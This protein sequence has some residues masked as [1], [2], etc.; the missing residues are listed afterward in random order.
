MSQQRWAIFLSGKGS[1]AQAAL[2]CCS[3]VDIRLVVSSREDAFGLV[4]ARRNGIATHILEK[5]INWQK[6]DVELAERKVTHIF[7]LGF[8]KLLPADFCKKW[9]S[10]I[11]N[12]H[13]SLLPEHKG[14]EAIEKS[15]QAKSDMGVSI[16]HVTAGMDEGQIILQQKV[17]SKEVLQNENPALDAAQMRMSFSEQL[18]IRKMI[19]ANH[20]RLGAL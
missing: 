2:D 17:I 19:T 14:L 5:K 8:M 12:V 1:T 9:E 6:L 11:F 4:R 7:L 3:Q 15:Y 13:P 20:F 16:H 18:L 10:K